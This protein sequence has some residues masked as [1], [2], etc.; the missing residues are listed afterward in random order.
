MGF[1]VFCLHEKW[2]K[3]QKKRKSGWARGR[4]ET[5]A[6][7]PQD[8]EFN[9]TSMLIGWASQTLL[10]CVD[11][12]WVRIQ[13]DGCILS[14]F[15]KSYNWRGECKTMLSDD[16]GEKKNGGKKSRIL[17]CVLR[18][19]CEAL[20]WSFFRW[21]ALRFREITCAKNTFVS[22]CYDKPSQ[23]FV[24]LSQQRPLF[25]VEVSPWFII[26][27]DRLAAFARTLIT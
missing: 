24:K 7:K 17:A 13:H 15:T 5:L 9:S 19:V 14:L 2:G 4:K 10:S 22:L 11:Q 23:S 18:F 12:R 16:F 8:F 27:K 6:D 25:K 20:L 26:T 21:V 1:S 3:S